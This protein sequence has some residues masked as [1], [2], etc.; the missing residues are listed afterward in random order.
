MHFQWDKPQGKLI[1]VINGSAVFYEIDIRKQS[2]TLGK[3]YS[4][5]LNSDNQYMLWVPPGF[6]NGFLSLADNTIVQYKC[7]QYWNPKAEGAVRWN[8][9]DV[10]IPWGIEEPIVSAKDKNT[11]SLKEWLLTENSN[12]F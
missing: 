3:Y 9:K 6:A 5:N 11:V 12:I 1:R 8:D 7:T 2:K 10:N 4:V